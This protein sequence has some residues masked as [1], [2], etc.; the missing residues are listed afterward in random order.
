VYVYVHSSKSSTSQ[1]LPTYTEGMYT[2][3]MRSTLYEN[4]PPSV[5][6]SLVSPPSASV[7]DS[8]H[9]STFKKKSA[10][11]NEGKVKSPI[12]SHNI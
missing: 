2:G 5:L 6:S 12:I 11:K 3:L 4:D 7:S 10:E 1:S 8:S 9:M